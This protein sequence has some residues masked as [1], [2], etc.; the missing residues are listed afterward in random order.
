[1][2]CNL[3][4]HVGAWGPIPIHAYVRLEDWGHSSMGPFKVVSAQ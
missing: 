2:F 1:M 4:A 3:A